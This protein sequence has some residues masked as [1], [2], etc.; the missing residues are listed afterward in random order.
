[1]AFIDVGSCIVAKGTQRAPRLP[2]TPLFR[3]STAGSN[4]LAW[5]AWST[6]ATGQGRA[7]S[8]AS[9]GASTRS[10]STTGSRVWMRSR[11]TCV[12]PRSEEH[13]SELQSRE[14]LVCRLL[15]EKKKICVIVQAALV[16]NNGRQIVRPLEDA[17]A[18]HQPIGKG[19]T[20]PHLDRGHDH[21]R[22]IG[23]R[24]AATEL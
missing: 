12:M 13:T 3:S 10:G 2:Y 9:R 15:L 18:Q 17:G 22:E 20:G 21:M 5:L 4:S 14:K 1:S 16:G 19:H 11:R 23:S 6:I 8:Q 24:A 7:E